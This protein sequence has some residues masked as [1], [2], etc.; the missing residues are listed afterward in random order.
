MSNATSWLDGTTRG[1]VKPS[2]SNPPPYR[3]AADLL[4]KNENQRRV[5][6]RTKK[7]GLQD[8]PYAAHQDGNWT[9][10]GGLRLDACCN[11]RFLRFVTIDKVIHMDTLA[12]TIQKI[13][14][15]GSIESW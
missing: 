13:D 8:L 7:P 12:G 14:K 1:W 10:Q 3:R 2:P 5:E 15:A 9:D 11:L 6:A 4:A